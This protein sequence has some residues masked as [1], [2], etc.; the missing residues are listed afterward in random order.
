[1]AKRSAVASRAPAIPTIQQVLQRLVADAA[2]EAAFLAIP[3]QR[4]AARLPVIVA[5]CPGALPVERLASQ[6]MRR[7]VQRTMMSG[8]TMLTVG[9]WRASPE[10]SLSP[11]L[12]MVAAVCNE[13]GAICGALAI[14]L[15]S[16]DAESG[17]VTLL[18][19]SSRDMTT[20]LAHHSQTS[21]VATQGQARQS[22]RT[23]R[24][25]RVLL[26]ELRVPLGAAIYALDALVAKHAET[27]DSQDNHVAQVARSAILEAQNIV[28]TTS[29]SQ[30]ESGDPAQAART[31][32]VET[33]ASHARDLFPYAHARIHLDVP[34][35][36]PL[37]RVNEVHMTEVL[38]NLLE[39]A[40]KYSWPDTPVTLSA[41]PGSPG[42]VAITVRSLGA[43][44]PATERELYRRG[45]A[46][47]L[48]PG[49]V[50]RG[51]GLDIAHHFMTSMGGE[52]W[53][54][55][56]GHG[57]TVVSLTAPVATQP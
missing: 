52:L 21:A 53:I 5:H 40:L 24:G 55:Q 29:L 7:T 38:S 6:W 31:V 15:S 23:R 32:S 18:E 45:G 47:A 56:P 34:E 2:A 54:D 3:R 17:I 13:D 11:A 37:V 39:N 42:F 49:R 51:L 1:M 4:G 43:E 25:I 48:A 20:A 19:N 57:V 35:A 30:V 10:R 28:R 14:L 12:L 8:R 50:S 44:V 22:D 41:Q 16:T 27:W 46:G 26:H 33:I 9:R 36:L